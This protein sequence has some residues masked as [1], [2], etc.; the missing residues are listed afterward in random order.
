[1]RIAAPAIV[2]RARSISAS[3]IRTRPRCRCPRSR[4]FADDQLGGGEVLDGEPERLEHGQLVVVR[5]AGVRCRP[6]PRRA[7]RG[8]APRRA[9]REQQVAGLVQRRL[10]PV[11][12]ERSRRPPCR[13]SSSRAVGTLEPTAFTCVPGG[14]P[15]ALDDRL[16][17][18]RA[19]AD[20]V[21]LAQR[22]LGRA[23][24][25]AAPGADLGVG[26]DGAHRL[27]V[28]ARLDA[29]AEDRD[30][31]RVRPRERSRRDGRDGRRADLGDRRRV[32]ERAQLAGL[33]VVEQHGA[34][35]RVEPARRVRG[36]DHDLLERPDRVARR[37]G[38]AG[39]RPISAS[40]VR[41]ARHEPERLVQLA[42]RERAQH[43]VHRLDARLH[44]SSV[45]DL[46]LG[47]DEDAHAKS[48]VSCS[49]SGGES[50]SSSASSAGRSC[51]AGAARRRPP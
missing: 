38:S 1:M 39:I 3:G 26:H 21:G 23:A 47:E 49:R 28:R 10:A 33:A 34:L 50:S 51:S 8:C 19:G 24:V 15:V 12:E 29:G 35:V 6:A 11:D 20:D 22:L 18:A 44:V 14:E 9:P 43:L 7:R 42:A 46:V 30:D 31:A 45:A 41:R 2:S 32:Q 48:A 5:A 40:G 4:A 27:D 37:R 13:V 16:A 25:A 17:R 36:G